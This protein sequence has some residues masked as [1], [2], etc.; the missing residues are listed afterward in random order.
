MDLTER[1]REDRARGLRATRAA[2]RLKQDDVARLANIHQA[3]VAKAEAGRV[4]DDMF[5]L[6]E[7]VLAEL[8]DGD[9]DTEQA[10]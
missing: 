4:S 9:D 10:S 6:I 8:D 5:D 1:T 7:T 3:T 2:L